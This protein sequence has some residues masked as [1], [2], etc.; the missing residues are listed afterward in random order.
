[1]LKSL[2]A[3]II[4]ALAVL[5]CAAQEAV[6]DSMAVDSA[7]SASNAEFPVKKAV[8]AASSKK[9]SYWDHGFGKFLVKIDR[10]L[11]EGQLSGIDTTYQTIPKLNRQVY[12]GAYGYWQNYSNL[13]PFYFPESINKRIPGLRDGAY[14][15]I[16]A[17]TQQAEMELGI[18]WKGFALEIPIPIRNNYSASYG[19]AKNGSVWGFRL[20]YKSI[21]SVAGSK[22]FGMQDELQQYVHDHPDEA[23]EISKVIDFV[24]DE[25]IESGKHHINIFF[26]EGYYV[27]NHRKFSLSA[28]L[29]AD[30][31]QKRSAGS[32]M[33]YANYYQ[34]RYA[35][36]DI[37]ISD[38]DVYRTQ[39][40]SVGFG[41]G[42]NYSLYG[43]KLLFHLSAVPMFS[44]YSN[45][46]HRAKFNSEADR[47][48]YEAMYGDDPKF[49]DPSDNGRPDFRVNAFA[50]FAANYS[51]GRYVLSL[52]VNYRYY[53]FSNSKNLHIN[54]Q[55][56]DAQFNIGYRF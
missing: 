55:E 9:R 19:L 11:E 29:F 53:G 8:V 17:H 2:Y 26:G 16:N 10:F 14:Y 30:M 47:K 33:V 23:E 1:M 56:A 41:Y 36:K 5:P 52:L 40:V 6:A 15:K 21:N 18:D 20:R 48:Q 46:M 24:K 28:G 44:L 27:F 32:M 7:F 4:L 42:Y 49:Y 34:S 39:Q 35:V 37:L 45:L 13:I 50:R 31:V 38:F 51:L 25:R 3:I 12:L 43:G 22:R 54:N